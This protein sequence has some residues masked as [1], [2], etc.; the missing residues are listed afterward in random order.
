MQPLHQLPEAR[1]KD[2]HVLDRKLKDCQEGEYVRVRARVKFGQDE[3][4]EK[5][6]ISGLLEDDSFRAFFVSYNPRLPLIPESLI[7]IEGA[8]VKNCLMEIRSFY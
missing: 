8:L 4:G 2:V 1:R 6:R 3:I 7:E 5:P